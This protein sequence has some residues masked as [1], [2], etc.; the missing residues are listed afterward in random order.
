MISGTKCE[1]KEGWQLTE[2]HMAKIDNDV[3]VLNYRSNVDGSCMSDGKIEILKGPFRA[4]TIWAR[5]GEKWQAVFHAETLIVDQ[6]A[7]QAAAKK[8]MPKEDDKRSSKVNPA[9]AT[10][11]PATSPSNPLTDA[12][13]AA[14]RA[15]WNA[16]KNKDGKKIEE[17]TASE[18][19]FVNLFGTYFANKAEC[20]KD[21]TGS[22][23]DVTGVTLSDGIASEISPTVGIL[24]ATGTATGNCGGT[25]IS[26]IKIYANSVYVKEGDAWKWAFG[27]NSPF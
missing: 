14:E 5:N 21:W 27:F 7:P 8:E 12:L 17:L 16:W 18:I 24:T 22:L 9:A 20:I 25:D 26:S 19:T 15:V 4:S 13:M 11:S 2:P 6:S 23:C 1:V 10:K 3:Y